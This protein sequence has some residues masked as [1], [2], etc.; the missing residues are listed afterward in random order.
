MAS[1]W[2]ERRPASDGVRYRVRYRL[3]GR[4]SRALYAGSFG[5]MRDAKTRRGWIQGELAA[6]RAPNLATLAE[7]EPAPTLR[8]VAGRWQENRLDV[9]DSTRIQHSVALGRVL[10]L[11]GDRPVDEITPA[12]VAE[13]VGKLNAE[14]KARETIRKSISALAMVLDFVG[15]SPNPARDRVQVRLPRE[16]PEELE[17]PNAEHV[18]TVA[19]LLP[20]DYLIGLLVLDATGAR[21]GEVEAARVGDLDE[22]RKAWL[23]RGAVAKTRRPRWAA[24]PDDLFD[25]VVD[26]LPA[27]EDRDPVAPLFPG[28]TADRLRMAIARAC[29]DAGVPHFS[30]HALRHR[31]ISLLHRQGLSWAEIGDL[32]GQRSR[33]VTADIYTHVLIDNEEVD[34]VKLLTRVRAVSAP[35]LPSDAEE[36]AFAGRF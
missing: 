30:P 26:R 6:M 12:D 23:V 9:R 22:N 31:R 28:V 13:L 2:I 27:R 11:L 4:E 10:P 33:M 19:W 14:G 35:V 29:R 25:V 18:E 24:L 34:R 7:P 5:T 1:C 15:I 36:S 8:T 17:P 32:V 16:E 20:V 21:I 3:G